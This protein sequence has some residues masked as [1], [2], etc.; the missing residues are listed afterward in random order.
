MIKEVKYNGYTATP[1]DYECPDGDLAGLMNIVPDNGDL[2]PVLPPN[3]LFELDGSKKVMYIHET[4]KFLHY[5]ILDPT[6]NMLSWFDSGDKPDETTGIIPTTELKTFGKAL[7][8]YQV[9]A[10]GNTL[11][12]Q[13]A[14]GMH[15]FLW[16]GDTEGYLYLGT[17]LPELPISFGLQGE[18]MRTDEFEITF[19][20]IDYETNKTTWDGLTTATDPFCADFSD[21]NK[22]KVTSQVLAKVNKF[23]AENATNKGKFIF[24][25]LVRYAYRLYD[26]SLTM[27]S[28]PVL[29][30]CSSDVAPDVSMHRIWSNDHKYM[31]DHANCR[32][33]GVVH[34]LDYACI[35]ESQITALKE[36]KDI[37]RSVDI[38][39]SKPI[40]T[41]DQSGEC[42]NF[43]R[44]SDRD[45]FSICKLTNQT[46][47]TTTYPVRYQKQKTSWMYCKAFN[48]WD[49]SENSF[50]IYSYRVGLPR[51]ST[52]TVKA[53]IKACA[54]FYLL[55]SIKLDDLTTTRTKLEVEDDYLQSLVNRESMSDDYDSHDILV[56]KYS[57]AYNQ[58]LNICNIEKQLYN[59]YNTGALLGFTDGLVNYYSNASPTIGDETYSYVVYFHIKQ[60]GK[61]IVVRGGYFTLGNDTPVL[62]LYYPN[63]N[64]YKATVVYINY[65]STAYEVSMEAHDFLNG[66]IYFEN[67]DGA[68]VSANRGSTPTVSSLADRTVEILNKIYT[69]DVNNPFRFAAT[70]I[71]TVGTGRILGIATAAKALSQGQFGQFPLYAFTTEGVW[72]MEVSTT[73]GSYSARQPITRDVCI[74]ADSIT[75]ID[76]AVL[77]AT[78]RGIMLI[79]GSESQCISDILNGDEVF[80]PLDLP[81]GEELITQAGFT[82]E[83]L[84]YIPFMDF[85]KNCGMLYDYTHQRIIVY[86][87]NCRYAYVYSLK[88]KAWGMM[89]SNIEDG[90][91]S[92]PDALAMNTNGTLVN[93]SDDDTTDEDALKGIKGIVFTRPFKLDGPDLLKTIDTIIQ[94]GY[95]NKD[96]V[97][98]VLYGSRDLFNWHVV[99]SSEDIYLRGFRGT[100]YKYFRLAL[101][102]QLDAAES[103]YGFTC[104]FTPRLINQPR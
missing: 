36:W 10:I 89:P 94:R 30:L 64:C 60:D 28:S 96:H 56:S 40:Y 104:Q 19:N 37:V 8:V 79:S 100:P 68:M 39:I 18:M 90:L 62:F 65:F 69:S 99:W 87:P 47:S 20:A 38:F 49:S 21:E 57:F 9:N 93:Y 59:N 44:T 43:M 91:N 45:S 83:Q 46:V 14:D 29:M 63:V 78:D 70:N 74:N 53:N 27:H 86:N 1:S 17:H 22:T 84:N 85:L 32:V 24:P 23:I 13:C 81:A 76:S 7:D 33:V 35:L 54:Q 95:V 48:T 11:I 41:Y 102:C 42:T 34:S 6:N 12:A 77:F 4:S 71:N 98:Q 25:F 73:T 55:E 50:T 61:E 16:K 97:Q 103:L 5:I 67:W 51:L 52:E 80:N 72:A 82:T 31:G 26:G 2:K 15:Y 3:T 92:Y 66:A 101:L 75:Q 58:R 88:D